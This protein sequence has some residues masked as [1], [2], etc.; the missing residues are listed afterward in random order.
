MAS[1]QSERVSRLAEGL[2]GSGFVSGDVQEC[3]S[4]RRLV[5]CARTMKK[6]NERTMIC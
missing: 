5:S 4:S 6:N 3:P 1:V 2:D